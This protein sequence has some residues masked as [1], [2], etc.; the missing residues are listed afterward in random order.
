M[1][2]IYDPSITLQEIKDTQIIKIEMGQRRIDN[3][4]TW[5]L[6]LKKEEY[7]KIFTKL[8]WDL[9]ESSEKPESEEKSVKYIVSRFKKWQDL[10]ENI[11]NQSLSEQVI[12]GLIGELFFLKEYALPKYGIINS[13]DGWVGPLGGDKDFLY[14]DYWIEIKSIS[15]GK[16]N[17][18]VS[19]LE[20]LDSREEGKLFLIYIEKSTKTDKNS[21]TLP[22]LID[23]IRK[24]LIYD[25]NALEIFDLK[26]STIGDVSNAEHSEKYYT[27]KKVTEYQI[28]E[29]FPRIKRE[30]LPPEITEV[31]YDISISAI[32]KWERTQ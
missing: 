30:E 27:V 9:I 8:C 11:K 2:L 22:R 28:N 25:A 4:K 7:D 21:I 13:I 6:T 18:T 5:I 12:K 26:V 32:K 16:N 23:E 10:L 17:F 19:S 31:I 15:P 1:I 20:Q 29:S 24:E 14:Q 3:R